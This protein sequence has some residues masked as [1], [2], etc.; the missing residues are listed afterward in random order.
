MV[1]SHLLDLFESVFANFGI[2]VCEDIPETE[3]TLVGIICIEQFLWDHLE[4]VKGGNV[5]LPNINF[6]ICDSIS[7]HESLLIDLWKSLDLLGLVVLVHLPRQVRYVYSCIRLPRNVEI[8]G[9][10]SW[11]FFVEML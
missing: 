8:I 5:G 11:E 3:V 4:V 7:Y 2:A 6:E 9:F 10:K 1:S